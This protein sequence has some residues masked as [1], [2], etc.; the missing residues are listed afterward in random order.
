MIQL[1]NSNSFGKNNLRP[2]QPMRCTLG[3]VLR[4]RNV[5]LLALFLFDNKKVNILQILK[6]VDSAFNKNQKSTLKWV[7]TVMQLL[8]IV[9][10]DWKTITQKK[11]K[12]VKFKALINCI[13]FS[14]PG[15]W[16]VKLHFKLYVLTPLPSIQC[17]QRT[18]TLYS[19]Q[20]ALHTLY[21]L[22]H[23]ANCNAKSHEI[24]KS[25][26]TIKFYQ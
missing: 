9:K 6:C 15:G 24:Y 12:N 10:L 25:A 20:C 18:C 5:F 17:L 13:E 14:F 7:Y 19:E 16:N 11:K 8:S 26:N 22:L 2:W 3:S 4:S 21:P 23:I 1:Q